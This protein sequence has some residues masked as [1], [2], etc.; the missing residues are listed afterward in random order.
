M[1][2]S[3]NRTASEEIMAGI[4][5]GEN[6]GHCGSFVSVPILTFGPGHWRGL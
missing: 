3:P 2:F 4:S 1:Y 6:H 5:A